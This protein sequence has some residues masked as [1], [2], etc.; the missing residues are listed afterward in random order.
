MYHRIGKGKHANSLST[1][2]KHFSYIADHFSISTPNHPHFKNSSLCITFDDATYDFYYYIY[3]LLKKYHLKAV[4]GIPVKYIIDHTTAS[5]QNRLNVPNNLM[6]Q[7]DFYEKAPF[8]TWE[9]INEMIASGH[10]EVAS[11]T[12]SHPN[13]VFD[14]VD[15]KKE[16]IDSKNKIIE[17]TDTVPKA[18]VYPFGKCNPY[19]E[20]EIKKNYPYS[21]RIGNFIN[22]KWTSKKALGRLSADATESLKGLINPRKQWALYFKGLIKSMRKRT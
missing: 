12:H 9:E 22:Q 2:E 3:P 15:L 19:L 17:K 14:F 5:S 4:L 20:N 6:M 13:L 7:D 10:V 18:F 21:F 1:Y 16:V 11:H 8:C